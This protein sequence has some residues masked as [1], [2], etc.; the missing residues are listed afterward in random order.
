M[1]ISK[2]IGKNTYSSGKSIDKWDESNKAMTYI[3]NFI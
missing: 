2:G 3:Y 1:I